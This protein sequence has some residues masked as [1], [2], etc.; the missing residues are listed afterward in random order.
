ME[1][2]H[3][4]QQ[5]QAMH[6]TLHERNFPHCVTEG[7]WMWSVYS[8]EKA[9]DFNGYLIQTGPNESIIVDPPCAGPEVLDGMTPLPDPRLII[10]TNR[11][12]ERAA[13]D[14]KQRFGIPVAAPELDAPL[15]EIH[16]DRTYRDGEGF[17]GGWRAIHLEN[18]KSPGE[19]AL[20]NPDRKLLVLGDVLIGKPFQQL[21][22]LPDDKYADPQAALRGLQRLA[23]LD[24]EGV[25]VCDGDPVFRC[26]ADMLQDAIRPR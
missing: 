10:I 16:P 17:S 20:Y 24:V 21:S 4:P 22:M 7:V 18:Q 23:G 15:M 12:H 6:L 3:Y 13:A 2:Q 25:L 19:S 26:A 1:K 11:D 14:F 5:Y 8:E 9:L